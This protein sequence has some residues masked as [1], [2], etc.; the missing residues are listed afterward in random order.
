MGIEIAVNL[1]L[2]VTTAVLFMMVHTT[3]TRV[4]LIVGMVLL[5]AVVNVCLKKSLTK[6]DEK[7]NPVHTYY[8]SFKNSKDYERAKPVLAKY[9]TVGKKTSRY[10]SLQ[11]AMNLQQVKNAIRSDL[12]LKEN[13]LDV[14]KDSFLL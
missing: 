9:G 3:L 1:I 5:L 10:L 14:L 7:G 12:K 13:E 11:T 8:V 4:L 6:K 2:L